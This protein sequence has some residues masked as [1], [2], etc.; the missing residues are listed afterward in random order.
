ML[1]LAKVAPDPDPLQ[2]LEFDLHQIE[3][4]ADEA[5]AIEIDR[6]LRPGLK[7]G[8]FKQ[9]LRIVGDADHPIFDQPK[10]VVQGLDSVAAHAPIGGKQTTHFFSGHHWTIAPREILETDTTTYRASLDRD[11][12]SRDLDNLRRVLSVMAESLA[13]REILFGPATA[14]DKTFDDALE[15]RLKALN[16]TSK[17]L[18]DQVK[19]LVVTPY[20]SLTGESG[21]LLRGLRD[22]GHFL[23]TP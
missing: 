18:L 2:D 13:G 1:A 17:D 12:G 7:S 14:R 16:T 23:V 20:E 22:R 19:L 15:A 11:M 5:A 10:A 6:A 4:D 21:R 3:G 9:W 8:S